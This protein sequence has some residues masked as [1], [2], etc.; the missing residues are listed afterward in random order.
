MVARVF[1]VLG[2]AFLVAAVGLALL[3]PSGMSLSGGIDAV[4]PTALEWM[5]SRSASWLWFS[6][7]VPFLVRPLWLVPTCV[8]LLCAG[9]AG[10]L[11]FKKST[12][13]R[14]RRS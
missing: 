3:T 7:E 2:S 14:P 8:G 11:N 5:R 10:S 1:A 12:N 4:L 9:I 6:I 13:T